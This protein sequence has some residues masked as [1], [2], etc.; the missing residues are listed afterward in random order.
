MNRA[1]DFATI[2]FRP[3]TETEEFVTIGVVAVETIT[4]Q[5]GYNLLD[6]R[7]TG[8]ISA[9]FPESVAVYRQAHKLLKAELD[10]IQRAVNDV[11]GGPALF[12]A[13]IS[14]REGVICFPVK[15]RRLAFDMDEALHTLRQRFME[16]HLLPGGDK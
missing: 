15:G 3:Y 13:V 14:P 10:A 2:G 6:S 1:F 11:S 5:L 12:S 7:K 4:R 9:M 8:R 16:R